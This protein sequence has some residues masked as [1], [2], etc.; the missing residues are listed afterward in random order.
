M[1]KARR[2]TQATVMR[3]IQLWKD[4]LH[5]SHWKFAIDFSPDTEDG[6][7]ASC[8]ASPEY[9]HAV[10]RFDLDKIPP[11]EIDAYVA[12]EISHCLIWPLANCAASMAGEDQAK[13]ESVR[14]NEEALATCLERVLIG[15]TES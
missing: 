12:H 4:R 9:L 10:L 6:S 15:L 2:L 14:V 11:E 7:E 5:L 1:K 13:L 8:L 3:K